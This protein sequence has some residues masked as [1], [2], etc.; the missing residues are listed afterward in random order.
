M[1]YCEVCAYCGGHVDPCEVHN[2]TEAMY[3]QLT[4]EN[5]RKFNEFVARLIEEQNSLVS[6]HSTGRTTI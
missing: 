6:V 1:N 3:S 2:C 4:E 5:K